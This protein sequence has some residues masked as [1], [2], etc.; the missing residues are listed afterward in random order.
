MF[1]AALVLLEVVQHGYLQEAREGT[2]TQGRGSDAVAW[3]TGPQLAAVIMGG[4]DGRWAA[5][6][7]PTGIGAAAA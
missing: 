3:T 6:F 7:S 4:T 1:A 2:E 5:A